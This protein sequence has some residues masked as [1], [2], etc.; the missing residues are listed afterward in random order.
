MPGSSDDSPAT[1]KDSSKSIMQISLLRTLM[2]DNQ[3][4]MDVVW[5]EWCS[6]YLRIGPYRCGPRISEELTYIIPIRCVKVLH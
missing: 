6:G 3:K 5:A 4:S 1:V 2:V